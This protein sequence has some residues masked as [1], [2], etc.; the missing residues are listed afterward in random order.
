M[1][2][3][4][5]IS[6]VSAQDSATATAVESSDLVPDQGPLMRRSFDVRQDDTFK[7]RGNSS[8][9][10]HV[11]DFRVA[12][13]HFVPMRR[14]VTQKRLREY[15]EHYAAAKASLLHWEKTALPAS[16]K[17]PSDLKRS[18]DDV[19]AVRVSSGNTVYVF[20]IERNAHRLIAAV[21]FNTEMVFVLRLMP[22]RE[23]DRGRW[24]DEL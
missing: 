19:D 24:K 8:Y 14:I 4:S 21:H 20:S 10:L 7:T 13:V 12:L 17:T 1:R 5:S 9:R 11:P 22:H 23:Y 2:F 16:W 3:G 15:A 18:F 6:R